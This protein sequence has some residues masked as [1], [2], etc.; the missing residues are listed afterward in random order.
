MNAVDRERIFHVGGVDCL[1]RYDF[2]M[3]MANVF[4]LDANLIIPTLQ[5]DLNLSPQRPEDVCLNSSLATKILGYKP[6]SIAEQLNY[7]YLLFAKRSIYILDHRVLYLNFLFPNY[8][9]Y[10][11]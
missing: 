6:S 5:K 1:S 7:L 9:I 8:L 11:F 2:A 4:K 3:R 10:H